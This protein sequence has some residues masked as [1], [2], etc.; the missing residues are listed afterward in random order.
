MKLSQLIG[1]PD[2]DAYME[3]RK[4]VER[5]PFAGKRYR[6]RHRGL[7]CGHT[8]GRRRQDELRGQR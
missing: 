8:S 3:P 7:T 4:L 5:N 6:R 1:I 2:M